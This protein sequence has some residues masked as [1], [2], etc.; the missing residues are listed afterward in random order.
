MAFTANTAFEAR[1][2]NNEYDIL[3]HVAGK[4]YA[5]DT[6]A[7]CDAG[8]LVVSNTVLPCEGFS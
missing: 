4:Y 8:R 7:D 6:E 3:S 5:S 1:L 2:T